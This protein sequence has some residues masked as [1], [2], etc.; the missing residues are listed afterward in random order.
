M[1]ERILRASVR[2]RS[3]SGVSGTDVP[4]AGNLGWLLLIRF[5][6]GPLKSP[7]RQG[8]SSG[9]GD[10]PLLPRMEGSLL[11]ASKSVHNQGDT[12]KVCSTHSLASVL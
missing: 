12:G 10:G 11:C 4:H 9:D 6:N 3:V 5:R 1:Y 2:Q 8:C 7:Y